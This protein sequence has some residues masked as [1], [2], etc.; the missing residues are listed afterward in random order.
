MK[1]ILVFIFLI[2][3]FVISKS[4]SIENKIIFKVNNQII[5]SLDMIKEHKYLILLNP[6][7]KQIEKNKLQKLSS[8][9]I[10]N[11]KV[12]EIEINKY[13]RN[14]RS[15]EDPNL[16]KIIQNLY[17]QIG[18][19]SE[20]EFEK[21][22]ISLNL[23]LRF[24]KEKIA[25]EMYWNNLIF[26]KYN[27]QVVI[28]NKSIELEIKNEIKKINKIKEYNLS[29][30]LIRNEKDLDINNFYKEI[31]K[32]MKSIGFENTAT[33]YSKSDTSKVGGKIGWINETSLSQKINK[34]INKLKKGE[35]SKPIKI[36]NNF[37]IIK[38]NDIKFKERKIDVKKLLENRVA[39]EKNLQLERFS[40]AHLNKVKK[41][42]N[43]NEL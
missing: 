38:I 2:L 23:N 32:S 7:L 18:L 10:I 4:N 3:S 39:F 9:S 8:D 22:L 11:E 36:S 24:I 28:D 14:E 41:N 1:K 29:E 30:I 26:R 31:I 43:I 21:Y 5:T 34:N 25:I 13:F 35:V 19:S 20:T 12:K 33:L 40:I 27:N 42:I 15:L 16:K 17:K 6:S 37:I